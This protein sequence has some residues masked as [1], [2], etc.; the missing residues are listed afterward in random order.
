MMGTYMAGTSPLES[1]L[2]V[3]FDDASNYARTKL[4]SL[5]KITREVY[6]ESLSLAKDDLFAIKAK[7]RSMRMRGKFGH[8]YLAR[9]KRSNH[10]V[11]LKADYGTL[12]YLPPEMVESV[13]HDANADKWSLGVQCYDFLYGVPP[14]E[15]NEH[16]DTYKR[17][18]QVDLKFPP[19]PNCP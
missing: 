11:A 3:F 7:R 1:H 14:F 4:E 19:K 15:A 10:I 2:K 8:V 6:E 18:I 17:I 9:E 12:D 16:S 5:R 13:E